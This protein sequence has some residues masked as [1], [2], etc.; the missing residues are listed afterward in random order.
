MLFAVVIGAFKSQSEQTD[1]ILKY[2]II[3]MKFQD[4]FTLKNNNDKN[5]N[6]VWYSF[7]SNVNSRLCF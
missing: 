5:Q 1:D 6:V 7:A 2:D 3:P 4:L